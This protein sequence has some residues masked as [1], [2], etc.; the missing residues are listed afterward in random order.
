[1]SLPK[2]EVCGAESYAPY[3]GPKCRLC[4][5]RIAARQDRDEIRGLRWSIPYRWYVLRW[6]SLTPGGGG[7]PESDTSPDPP[8][9]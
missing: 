6:I 5:E 9:V 3:P 1:M 8:S 4:H 7:Q 2:C